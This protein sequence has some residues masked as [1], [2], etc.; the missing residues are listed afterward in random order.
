MAELLISQGFIER[1]TTVYEELVRRRPFDPVLVARLDELRLRL[2]GNA[3]A[4]EQDASSRDADVTDDY[5]AVPETA[6]ES[7]ASTYAIEASMPTPIVAP[8]ATSFD[9][10]DA[11]Q[12]RITAR[13]RFARLAT[14]RVPRRT[15]P[16]AAVALEVPADSL[17]G[18][19]GAADEDRSD[20]YAARAFADAFA[21]MDEPPFGASHDT[22][23]FVSRSVTAPSNPVI[24]APSANQGD[25][26]NAQQAPAAR[27]ASGFS[28]D[29]F[30]PDPATVSPSSSATPGTGAKTPSPSP[31]SNQAQSPPVSDDLAEFAAWLKGLDKP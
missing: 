15:P 13:E 18:L 9:S 24:P 16:R 4:S 22:P 21:P 10:D 5:Q 6:D 11:E 3:V 23:A 28:F 17:A 19:F 2:D 7:A 30:F 20:D 31:A 26:T 12:V 25:A 27:Q 1:A 29:R 8:R 14:R